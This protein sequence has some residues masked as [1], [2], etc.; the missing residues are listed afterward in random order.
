[1]SIELLDN[2]LLHVFLYAFG[3]LVLLG[4]GVAVVSGCIDVRRRLQ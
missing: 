1:M 2:I 3:V 4:S